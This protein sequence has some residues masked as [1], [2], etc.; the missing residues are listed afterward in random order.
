MTVINFTIGRLSQ[1]T[2]VAIETIRYYEKCGLV[3]PP[4]RTGAGVIGNQ[5]LTSLFSK[6]YMSIL[7]KQNLIIPKLLVQIVGDDVVI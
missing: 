4:P 3:A 1:Q 7:G 6:R 2:G 5:P